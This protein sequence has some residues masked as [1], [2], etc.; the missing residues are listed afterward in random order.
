MIDS[1]LQ[2]MVNW[3]G[4]GS[5]VII[6]LARNPSPYA[7]D[8]VSI[9]ESSPSAVFVS[10]DYGDTYENRTEKFASASLDKFFNH[11]KYNHYVSS[12][13]FFSNF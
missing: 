10:Y 11:Q 6:C 7:Q 12:N 2:L 4:E 13:F 3:A 5:D 1:H 9:E 8:G